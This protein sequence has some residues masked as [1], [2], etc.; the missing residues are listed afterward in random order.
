M[1][2]YGLKPKKGKKKSSKPQAS[3]PP[4]THT[5]KKVKVDIPSVQTSIEAEF[6]PPNSSET[7]VEVTTGDSLNQARTYGT[8]SNPPLHPGSIDEGEFPNSP[9]AEYI[10][11]LE[12]RL[13]KMEL[14]QQQ[15]SPEKKGEENGEEE[16]RE[17][18]QS[19][20]VAVAIT[21]TPKSTPQTPTSKKKVKTPKSSGPAS[22][23]QTPTSSSRIASPKRST[24]D[25]KGVAHLAWGVLPSKMPDIDSVLGSLPKGDF[26]VGKVDDPNRRTG[27]IAKKLYTQ[28]TSL[29]A[30]YSAIKVKFDGQQD[31]IDAAE[32]KTRNANLKTR[33]ATS[34][35]SALR[36]EVESKQAQLDALQAMVDRLNQKQMSNMKKLMAA[37]RNKSLLTCWNAWKGWAG[38]EKS[39]KQKMRKFLNKWNNAGLVRVF[40]NWVNAV[41]EAKREQ[42]LLARFAARWKQMNVFKTFQ[43]WK[44]TWKEA[45]WARELAKK[46]LDEYAKNGHVKTQN[47][48]RDWLKNKGFRN[49][50]F[51]SKEASLHPD[52]V[53]ELKK[54]IKLLKEENRHLRASMQTLKKANAQRS[55]SPIKGLGKAMPIMQGEVGAMIA[56]QKYAKNLQTINQEGFTEG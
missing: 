9:V 26:V 1:S 36:A 13:E 16:K 41:Q 10:S 27:A 2:H 21:T 8:P 18:P 40:T 46:D 23:P 30:H 7:G 51:A 22:R 11:K 3:R 50:T 24:V 5:S 15:V 56:S 19:E 42:R 38:E 6:T 47:T 49:H 52:Q 17:L 43:S 28:L 12:A 4:K 54:Q 20:G 48:D 45:K 35:M 34:R 37:W 55:V 25:S 33:K 44:E 32:R 29:Y 14:W 31:K 39:Q 53:K